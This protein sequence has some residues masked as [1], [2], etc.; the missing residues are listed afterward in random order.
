MDRV[1]LVYMNRDIVLFVVG[2]TVF[3][4]LVILGYFDCR[5]LMGL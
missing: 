1:K 2:I 5:R 4:L 3:R